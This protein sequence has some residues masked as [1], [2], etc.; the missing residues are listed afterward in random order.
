MSLD[1]RLFYRMLPRLG[2]FAELTLV[3]VVSN[4]ISGTAAKTAREHLFPLYGMVIP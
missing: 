1:V 3:A 4:L 2:A